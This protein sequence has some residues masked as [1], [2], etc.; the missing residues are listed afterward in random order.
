MSEKTF[1]PVIG[2]EI[3]IQLKTKSKMFCACPAD[4]ANEPNSRI[5][6]VCMGLPGSLPVLNRAA[7]H[8]G[9]LAG[10]ALNCAVQ[11]VTF[12]SRKAYF[13]PDLPKGFQTSGC[14][15]PIAV[16]GWL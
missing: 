1:T 7:V 16:N 3:H 12:F 5:C 10:M 11:P 6:P 4:Y 8:Q 13:Y 15:M 2:I 9:M 14:D